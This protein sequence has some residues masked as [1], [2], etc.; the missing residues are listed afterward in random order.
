MSI[1]LVVAVMILRPL[2]IG[3]LGP[4]RTATQDA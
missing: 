2:V 3:A 4:W 1:T